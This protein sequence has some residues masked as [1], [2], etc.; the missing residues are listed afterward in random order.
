M[1]LDT[2][3]VLILVFFFFGGIG[4]LIWKNSKAET[5]EVAEQEQPDIEMDNQ[6]KPKA[7]RRRRGR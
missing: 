4:F 5:P 7:K 2:I 6:A 3:V 1:G